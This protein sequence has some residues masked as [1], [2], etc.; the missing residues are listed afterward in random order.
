[1]TRQ[2]PYPV[3]NFSEI[4]DLMYTYDEHSGA[5]NTGWPQLNSSRPLVE[6]NREYVSFT[7]D[8]KAK[9]DQLLKSGLGI[10]AQPSR[11]ETPLRRR[12]PPFTT[13]SF[14][15]AIHGKEMMSSSSLRP[16]SNLRSSGSKM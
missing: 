13:P 15:T 10:I 16:P 11:Y 5:G 4:Y 6:Q 7:R 1:M 8:A 9:T 14:T 2:I 3:G 12:T